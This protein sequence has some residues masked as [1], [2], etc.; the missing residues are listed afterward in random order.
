MD[1]EPKNRLSGRPGRCTQT[2]YENMPGKPRRFR[3][4]SRQH[5][6]QEQMAK[7][8]R[9]ERHRRKLQKTEKPRGTIRDTTLQLE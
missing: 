7:Q 8:L 1:F 5:L 6:D 9:K 2:R 3:R 4:S